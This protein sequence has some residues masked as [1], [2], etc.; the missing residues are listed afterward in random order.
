MQARLKTESDIKIIELF[1]MLDATQMLN[2]G[3]QSAF[4]KKT[5]DNKINGALK[6]QYE[7]A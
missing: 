6:Q 2:E 5:Y 3:K 4:A 1:G 7:K